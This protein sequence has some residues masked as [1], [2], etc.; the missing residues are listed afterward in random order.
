MLDTSCTP[1][2]G[3]SAVHYEILVAV[4]LFAGKI[5]AELGE[6]W[7]GPIV[8]RLDRKLRQWLSR[9]DK[10]YR[11]FVLANT[12]SNDHKDNPGVDHRDQR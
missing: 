3:D 10:R 4:L 8:D 12:R 11:E 5:A 7:Q 9:F 2:S 1:R 6:P